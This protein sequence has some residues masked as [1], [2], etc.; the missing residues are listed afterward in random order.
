[1]HERTKGYRVSESQKQKKPE[2]EAKDLVSVSVSVV[3]A[4]EG[5][6]AS[7]RKV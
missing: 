5:V 4:R 3:G 1:M 7:V 2:K 6:L